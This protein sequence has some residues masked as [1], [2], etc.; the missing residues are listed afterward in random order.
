MVG[1]FTTKSFLQPTLNKY[2]FHMMLQEGEYACMRISPVWE[3]FVNNNIS[4]ECDN[5]RVELS[6][7]NCFNLTLNL[8]WL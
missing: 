6:Q 3:H 8:I 7:L 5:I 1:V 4:L 2:T